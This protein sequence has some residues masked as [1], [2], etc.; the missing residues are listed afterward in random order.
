MPEWL[1]SLISPSTL[2]GGSVVAAITALAAAARKW[3]TTLATQARKTD[4]QEHEQDL[5]LSKR[6]FDRLDDVEGRLDKAEK[7]QDQTEEDLDKAYRA[8]DQYQASIDALIQRIDRL[9]QRLS[10]YEHISDAEWRRQTSVPVV[11]PND[12]NP[13]RDQ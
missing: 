8:I 10:E 2:F 7:K 5:S 3:Y 1:T 9:L 6:A 13:D 11:N 12:N 4:Q